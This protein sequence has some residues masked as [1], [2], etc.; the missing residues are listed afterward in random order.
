MLQGQ[1]PLQEKQILDLSY[2]QL[3]QDDIIS[4]VWVEF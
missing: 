2:T 4:A 1:I 3:I